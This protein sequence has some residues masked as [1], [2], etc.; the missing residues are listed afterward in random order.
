VDALLA[1]VQEL[2][3]AWAGERGVA[4]RREGPGAAVWADPDKL[5]RVLVNLVSNALQAMPEGGALV[6]STALQGDTVVIAIRD[7]GTGLADEA[8]AHLF[9]PYFTTK[10]EGTGL[11]LAIA[12]RA[13]EEMGGEIELASGPDGVGTV[14]RVHLPLARTGGA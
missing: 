7:T 3:Q 4:V 1:E 11:G 10:S 12:K 8:R 2:H 5:R 14:A 6:L 9:E 13:L